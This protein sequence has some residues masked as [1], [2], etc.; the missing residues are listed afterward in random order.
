M[1]SAQRFIFGSYTLD[2]PR[3]TVSFDYRVEFTDGSSEQYVDILQFPGVTPDRWEHIPPDILT[4]LLQSLLLMLGINYWKIHCAPEM[5][6][7]GFRLTYKQ[8]QFWNTLYTKGLGEFFYRAKVDFRGLVNFPYSTVARWNRKRPTPFIRSRRSLV[9]HG[10]GKDSVV[11]AEILK[12]ADVPFDLFVLRGRKT[13]KM[14]ERVADL[15]AHPVLEV[16]RIIDTVA[17]RIHGVRN[18]MAT[19]PS[20]SSLTF[21]AVLVAALQNYRYVVLSNESSA[22]EG[23]VLYLG[24]EANHQWSKSTESE[25]MLREY[26]VEYITPDIVPF[27]LIRPYSE[28]EMVRQFS[29]Y[30]NY[31][32]SFSSCNEN[33]HAST[34]ITDVTRDGRV[35]WC[36][37]CPKCIFIFA[38]LTAFLP[39][40]VVV[41]IFGE[42]LYANETFLT[43]Y[44]EL[45]GLEG[46]KPFECVGTAEEM[47]VAMARAHRTG[48][49]KGDPIMDYFER[50]VLSRN[51]TIE[52]MEHRVLSPLGEE[53]I[54]KGFYNI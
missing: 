18:P 9:T 50:E 51:R 5:Q 41:E 27:S 23:N 12:A 53:M 31:F 11:T 3:G 28:I 36:N 24:L 6:I 19:F 52:E 2:A 45:L 43:T 54:P 48:S 14:Q 34:D 16:R 7:E 29:A 35:Y 17:L 15:V 1:Q 30:P 10:G 13:P 32:H 42:N 47:I 46:I 44:K 37:T 39:K 21:I 8:A 38:C 40:E 33:F 26:I 25:I 22:D 4:S 49:Y 20:V